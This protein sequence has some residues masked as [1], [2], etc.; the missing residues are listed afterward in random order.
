ML[1]MR[2][3]IPL[4]CIAPG[5]RCSCS[6]RKVITV[7][8]FGN[9]FCT[10][11]TK[12]G[13]RIA[14]HDAVRDRVATIMNYCGIFTTTE[15]K[16]LFRETDP[17]DAKRTDISALNLPGRTAKQL[18]DIRIT[19]CIPSIY[20]ESLTLKQA[21]IPLRAAN[22]SFKEKMK[23][24]E[25]RAKDIGLGFIP[26][27]FETTGRMHPVT[28][29]LLVEVI[30]KAATEKGAPFASV[31]KYWI[32]SLMIAL[33]VNLSEGIFERCSNIYGRMFDETFESRQEVIVDIDY[34]R[35]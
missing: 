1:S 10:G 15:E 2:L 14:T 8:R 28:R 9:H 18:L 26:I 30:Q 20:P 24:Y 12:D 6:K 11:C 16:N 34:I 21:K 27:V 35:A 25:K 31:W 32:S 13:V 29:A 19:S 33:Q 3:R 17:D 22:S 7:D 5:T 4:K 23:K